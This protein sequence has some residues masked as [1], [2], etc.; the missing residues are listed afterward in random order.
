MSMN[1]V[2]S[3]RPPIDARTPALIE[4]RPRDGPIVAFLEIAQRGRQRARPQDQRQVARFLRREAP[5]NPAFPVDAALDDRRRLDEVVE[6][7]RQLPADVRAGRLAELDRAV[8]VEREADGRLVELVDGRAGVAKV[9]SGHDW[10]PA[11]EVQH[12]RRIALGA[13]E[14]GLDLH[15]RRHFAAVRLQQGRLVC[16]HAFDELDF[17]PRGLPDELFGAS[18]VVDAGH[19]HDDLIAA[20][21][22]RRHDRLGDA[23]FVDAALDR[24]ERLRHGVR[25]VP[26]L[27]FGRIRK[28]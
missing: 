4:S 6:D 7:D 3:A 14:P 25:A 26:H 13:R 8:A 11:D 10:R 20:R 1:A 23:V 17:Q 9:G 2:T 15:I 19:L 12:L 16:R 22:V 28:T 21:P 18:R 24:L 27:M 5:R